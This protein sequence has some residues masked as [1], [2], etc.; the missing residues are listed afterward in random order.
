MYTEEQKQARRDASRRWYEKN[1]VYKNPY[2]DKVAET[3]RKASLKY[4]YKNKSEI[5]SKNQKIYKGK[6]RAKRADRIAKTLEVREEILPLDIDFSFLPKRPN[7]PF[8]AIW[9][10]PPI[11][12]EGGFFP[13]A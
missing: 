1:K 5:N 8:K 4:Y 6:V 3:A 2:P 12:V 9:G 13:L 7:L 11:K 10:D